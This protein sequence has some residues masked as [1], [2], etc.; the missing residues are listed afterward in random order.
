[1]FAELSNWKEEEELEEAQTGKRAERVA[2]WLEDSAV[3]PEG[4]IICGS[5]TVSNR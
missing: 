5:G 1:L 3:P 2:N 4:S